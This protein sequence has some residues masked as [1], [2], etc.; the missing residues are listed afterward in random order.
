MNEEEKPYATV[1]EILGEFIGQ[2]LLEI[3]QHDREEYE[4][5]KEAYAILHFETGGLKIVLADE[6]SHLEIDEIEYG[7]DQ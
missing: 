3:T 4:Q 6:L 5:T 7:E 1:R 2:R